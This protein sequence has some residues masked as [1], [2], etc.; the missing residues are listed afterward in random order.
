MQLQQQS[1]TASKQQLLQ[2]CRRPPLFAF[3]LRP[4]GLEARRILQ[5]QRSHRK[6]S[7][8]GSATRNWISVGSMDGALDSPSKRDYC[9]EP[10]NGLYLGKAANL[11]LPCRK[12]GS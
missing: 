3:C 12:L 4:R 7:V 1:L 11:P 2:Q 5:K 8:N 9:A 10:V 6:Q